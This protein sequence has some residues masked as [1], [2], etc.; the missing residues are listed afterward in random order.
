[1]C[2]RDSPCSTRSRCPSTTSSSPSAAISRGSSMHLKLRVWRQAGPDV[3]GSF[4][5]HD[6]ADISPDMSFLEMFDVLN[7]RLAAEGREPVA[8]D[9]DC[10]D[11]PWAWPLIIME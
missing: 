5:E 3:P 11:G 1:M 7:E 8:F 2:I 10:R 9:H 6:M 4:E